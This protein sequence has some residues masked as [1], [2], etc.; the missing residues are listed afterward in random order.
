MP[1]AP[2]VVLKPVYFD[3]NLKN[4]SNKDIREAHV[5]FTEIRSYREASGIRPESGFHIQTLA[6]KGPTG[7]PVLRSRCNDTDTGGASSG[8][9]NERNDGQLGGVPL[10]SVRTNR[11]IRR[12][13]SLPTSMRRWLVPGPYEIHGIALDQAPVMPSIGM[14]DGVPWLEVDANAG[15]GPHRYFKI[16]PVKL[17]EWFWESF[18]IFYSNDNL[19]WWRYEIDGVVAAEVKG[20]ATVAEA[21]GGYWKF[22][23][24]RSALNHGDMTYDVSDGH[25]GDGDPG[26]GAWKRGGAPIVINTAPVIEMITPRADTVL[27]A[28]KPVEVRLRVKD[29]SAVAS[30]W[31]GRVASDGNKYLPEIKTPPLDTDL[32]YEIAPPTMGDVG[33]EVHFYAA[34]VDDK[35]LAATPA[36]FALRVNAP[37]P[38]TDPPPPPAPVLVVGGR[39]QLDA[40]IT[41]LTNA[42]NRARAIADNYKNT[43]LIEKLVS[44]A[45][46]CQNALDAL[47]TFEDR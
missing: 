12:I 41:N 37:A 16:R 11:S 4:V 28:G 17:G 5:A 44:V 19:G 21:R 24:Y 34:A 27:E 46:A 20:E 42:R 6:E 39:D 35:G 30:L 40:A 45:G 15:R 23:N 3:E 29:D 14:Y 25:I 18:T 2:V 43:D 38:P 13:V 36:A 9:A 31:I 1:H 8:M 7:A 47:E 32:V 33:R 22:A 10:K 26:V